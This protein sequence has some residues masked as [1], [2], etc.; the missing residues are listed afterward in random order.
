MN[1][2]YRFNPL[3]I[4]PI[5]FSIKFD[6]VESK[7]SIVYTEGSQVDIFRKVLYYFL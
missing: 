3:K 6:T 2:L 7:K 1:L 5:E 4:R